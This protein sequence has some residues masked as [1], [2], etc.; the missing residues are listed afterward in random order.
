MFQYDAGNTGFAPSNSGP[1]EDVSEQRHFDVGVFDTPIRAR[2]GTRYIPGN[3][4]V[5]LS[6]DGTEQWSVD[7]TLPPLTIGEKYV[8]TRDQTTRR[9]QIISQKDGTV[10]KNNIPGSRV[11]DIVFLDGTI[12][13]GYERESA[14]IL[15]ARSST[16]EIL[17]EFDIEPDQRSERVSK[18][19][20]I[21]PVASDGV[22][23]VLG[24]VQMETEDHLNWTVYALSASD[25]TEQWSRTITGQPE[26]QP[27]VTNGKI[28]LPKKV[29]NKNTKLQ[30]LST[31]E[32]I[33]Q[34]KVEMERGKLSTPA[35]VQDNLY[36]TTDAYEHRGE[37]Q[38]AA[39]YAMSTSDGTEQWSTAMEPRLI[40]SRIYGVPI[41]VDETLYLTGTDRTFGE[42]GRL[43]GLSANDGSEHWRIEMDTRLSSSP[44]VLNDQVYVGSEDGK[45]R[46]FD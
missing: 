26:A 4:L 46:V 22:V 34:W 19:A 9:I 38:S 5:A 21:G 10:L 27:T 7:E 28:Y 31:E 23:Y 40:D 41:I 39:V 17:W 36:V 15:S 20:A 44:V 1:I 3:S 35:V 25:G 6:P 29:S 11:S 13:I 8:Y 37:F 32:G 12:Y 45:L 18:Y 43:I 33:E 2:N 14:K 42:R 30:A 24:G 16:G